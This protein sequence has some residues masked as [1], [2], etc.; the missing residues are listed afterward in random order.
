MLLKC[1]GVYTACDAKMSFQNFEALG[2]ACVTRLLCIKALGTIVLW[3]ILFIEKFIRPVHARKGHAW[4]DTLLWQSKIF[5]NATKAENISNGVG[6]QWHLLWNTRKTGFEIWHLME[7]NPCQQ[8]LC[9]QLWPLC[10]WFISTDWE[11]T[12]CESS[13][14]LK[15]FATCNSFLACRT[16][17]VYLW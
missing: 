6:S 16:W 15:C 2:Y 10:H 11:K 7:L 17:I 13:Y 5:Q 4:C 12:L 9:Y 3:K 14:Y 1:G 8:T